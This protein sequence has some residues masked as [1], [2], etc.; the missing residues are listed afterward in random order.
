M[1]L[2]IVRLLS[3]VALA[4]CSLSAAAD[5]F[6]VDV[7]PKTEADIRLVLQ[8][9]EARVADPTAESPPPI[10]MILHGAEAGRFLRS[11]YPQNK[12]MVDLAAQLSAYGLLD[13]Q[14]CETWMR[15]NAYDRSELFPFISTVP[16]APDEVQRLQDEGYSEFSVDL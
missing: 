14:I 16:F 15:N 10:I 8:T 12:A 7:A 1:R 13:V 6:Y 9:L 5:D 11:G 4:F 2:A 3:A